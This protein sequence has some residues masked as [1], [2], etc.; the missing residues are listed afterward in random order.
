M[1]TCKIRPQVV[2]RSTSIPGSPAARGAPARRAP[3]SG[4]RPPRWYRQGEVKGFA[5]AGTVLALATGCWLDRGPES[6]LTLEEVRAQPGPAPYFAGTEVAGLPLT[7]ID[8]DTIWPLTFVYGDC[9]PSGDDGG[10]APPLQVQVWPID[11]RPPGIIQQRECR[12]VE[13]RGA[14]GAFYGPDLDLY[15]GDFTISI[16][17]HTRE[18]VV[19]AAEALRT[20]DADAATGNLPAPSVGAD[21]ALAA[22]AGR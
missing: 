4:G 21:A 18:L 12:A 14:P 3:G 11:R 8:G 22:C 5:L 1:L 13:I 16:F 10:C 20:V 9:E 19:G 15:V 17:A 2:S 6:D 7:A